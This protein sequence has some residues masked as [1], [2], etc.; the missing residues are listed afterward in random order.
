MKRKYLYGI[1]VI[2]IAGQIC[3]TCKKDN[4]SLSTVKTLPVSYVSSTAATL[5]ISVESDGGSHIAQCGIFI[6]TSPNPEKAGQGFQIGSDTGTFV[7]QVSGFL[8]ETQYYVKAFALNGNGQ[9]LGNQVD[10]TTTGTV[11][12]YDNNTYETVKIGDQIWMASNLKTTSYSNGDPIE[13]TSPATADITGES[14]PKYQWAYEG[15][16][17]TARTY[18]RL[19]T[20]H[21]V[22]DSRGICPTGWHVPDDT[23]WT[24]L[25]NTLGGEEIAGGLMKETGTIHWDSPN[26]G[27]TNESLFSALAGGSRDDVSS[28]FIDNGAAAYFWSST[29]LDVV[30]AWYRHLP[31]G[32]TQVGR[33]SSSKSAGFSIRCVKD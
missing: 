33:I 27:A 15:D 1:M 9:S 18:G 21:A 12:D 23:E 29:D 13:T 2:M 19:Y 20:G 10:F 16:D 3:I 7:G 11:K 8:P 25:T 14:T 6:G 22:T 32:S 26:T 28:T 30:N 17:I 24:T 31:T 4:T 5:G